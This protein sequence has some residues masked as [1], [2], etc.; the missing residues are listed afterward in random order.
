MG[1]LVGYAIGLMF[2]VPLGD[3][4]NRRKLILTQLGALIAALIA[5]AT[6]PNLAVLALASVAIGICSTVAQQLIPMAASMAEPS[7]RGRV[8]GNIMSG[9]LIG[10][11]GA[12]VL[13]GVVAEFVGWRAMF[14][15]AALFMAVLGAILFVALP[16]TTP[17]NKL[18]YGQLM[19]S[20][21]DLWHR[22]PVLREASVVG[23]LL[24]ASF[25]GFWS[26]LTLYL[27]SPAFH[28]GSSI[29]G[30]FGLVG[31]AGAFAAQI[32]GRLSDRIGPHRVIAVSIVVTLISFA[33]F[34]FAGGSLIGLVIGVVLMDFGVQGAMI[35]NQSRVYAS[36]PDAPSRANTLF[37]V[38]YFILGALG[39]SIGTLA[40]AHAGWVG[41]SALG[42][43]CS[44]L[45]LVLFGLARLKRR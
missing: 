20:L 22:E 34:G 40:W 30:S 43:V 15:L 41:V 6:A 45:S 5:T 26:T 9:L 25:I 42:G 23:G 32:S 8:V 3:M 18:S 36:S 21:K 44:L 28:L 19:V 39:S 13:S 11:L 16:R 38:N 37:M 31:I 35:A 27:A 10:I 12:R 24:F 1:C 14:G 33:V 17:A 2:L 4:L 29:A 7:K